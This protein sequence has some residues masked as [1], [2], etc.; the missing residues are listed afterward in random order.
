MIIHMVFW[1]FT[2]KWII[3]FHLV[4]KL[5]L[6][7]NWQFVEEIWLRELTSLNEGKL[8]IPNK[9]FK[10]IKI[11]SHWQT[12]CPDLN[13]AT[14]KANNMFTSIFIDNSFD[15]VCSIYIARS[16]CINAVDDLWNLVY[17]ISLYFHWL[18]NSEIKPPLN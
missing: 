11:K 17:K 4:W 12:K 13:L 3:V 6:K 1:D 7:E 9:K 5:R 16:G 8:V 18:N 15:C 10:K 2:L 14:G